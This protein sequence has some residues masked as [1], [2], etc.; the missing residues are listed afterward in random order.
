MQS[1]ARNVQAHPDVALDGQIVEL[2][3]MKDLQAPGEGDA[4]DEEFTAESLSTGEAKSED[5]VLDEDVSEAENLQE[6]DKEHF[7]AAELRHFT[8]NSF[9]V[10]MDEEV[11][12]AMCIA[13][14]GGHGHG[15][16][17]KC[18]KMMSV[19]SGPQPSATAQNLNLAQAATEDDAAGNFKEAVVE[20]DMTAGNKNKKQ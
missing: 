19:M 15:N 17:E 4:K 14:R 11:D 9:E 1:R 8:T 13:E 3:G 7:D 10:A 12:E 18:V 20:G 5:A 6:A 2:L 16:Q